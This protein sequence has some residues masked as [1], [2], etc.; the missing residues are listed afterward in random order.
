MGNT[1]WKLPDPFVAV[2]KKSRIFLPF[3]VVAAVLLSF[4]FITNAKELHFLDSKITK[5][6]DKNQSSPKPTPKVTTTPKQSVESA[7]KSISPT[8]T[9]YIT[10]APTAAATNT[11]TPTN[12]PAPVTAGPYVVD[13]ATFSSLYPQ[14]ALN[15]GDQKVAFSITSTGTKTFDIYDAR[16]IGVDGVTLSPMS[17]SINPGETKDIIISVAPTSKPGTYGGY[18][19]I[20]VDSGYPSQKLGI[21]VTINGGDATTPSLQITGPANESTYNQ[22][23][24][25]TITWDA[26]NISGDFSLSISGE[27][28]DTYSFANVDNSKRSYTWQAT[29]F[30]AQNASHFRFTITGGGIVSHANN[31]I[32]IN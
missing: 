25:V 26:S 1:N 6:H 22:G 21:T 32:I 3:V 18:I 19:G 29:K 28:G 9:P 30:F 4:F 5:V 24:N 27:N 16:V 8:V 10:V 20:K 11:P 14:V 31:E 17:G 13:G 7:Q 15:P 2:L 23:D 12:T